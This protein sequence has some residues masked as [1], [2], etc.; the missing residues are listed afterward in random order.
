MNEINPVRRFVHKYFSPEN[1]LAEVIC[2]LI[3]VLTF[4]ATTGGT[5]EGTTPHA[6][7]IAVLG[8]NIA[9][10]I[11]DGVTYILGNLLNRGARAR[12]IR[13]LRTDPRNPQTIAAVAQRLD[14]AIGDVLTPQQHEQ[15]AEWVI[16]GL[17]KREPEPTRVIKQD[18]FTALAC[19]LIV[20]A[21]TLPVLVPFL[22]IRNDTLALRVANG[23]ILAMLFGI[24]WRWAAFANTS[25]WKTG[26]TLLGVGMVLVIITIALGG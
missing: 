14:S 26:L 21:A 1:R 3:M 23:L 25:R 22:L 4:T 15:L 18:V 9:W 11:V 17:S 12:L 6:L 16:D 7:L 19:F 10:G 5:F 13:E 24:G 2:G 8:C 20:F